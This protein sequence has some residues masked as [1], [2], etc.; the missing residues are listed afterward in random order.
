MPVQMELKRIIISEIHEQQV[1]M[2]KEVEGDRN[3]SI[4][5]G[6][7]EATSI[8]RRVKRLP[9]PRPLTHDLVAGVIEQPGRRTARHLHQRTARPHL[10]RQAPHPPE[11]RNGRGRLPAQRRHRPGRHRQR[12]HLRR[13]GRAGRSLR[14]V[15]ATNPRSSHATGLQH[16]RLS[17]L[18]LRRGRPPAGRAS[19]TRA[20]R[21]WPTCR[22]PGR[23]SCSHEQKQAI[24]DALAS[25]RPGHLQRQRLHDA[26]RQRPAAALLASVVDRAG[27]PLSPDPHRPHQPRPDP[28]PRTG[29][30]AA[31]PP[32][33]AGPS[34]RAAR[35]RR[36]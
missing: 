12:A 5:I 23:P 8:D 6:I 1:I 17:E 34:S 10:L 30:A 25:N 9:S 7:F 4:M 15:N 20:S 32:S 27:P 21:S 26:R 2:L 16:Q 14:R 13:R 11:R 36:R 3:F 28:G 35:G 18:L 33:R 19:A 29:R 22:T 31:S 24:R